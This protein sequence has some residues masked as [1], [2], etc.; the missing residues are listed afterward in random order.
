MGFFGSHDLG[1]L[2]FSIHSY[3]LNACLAVGTKHEREYLRYN[4]IKLFTIIYIPEIFA[5][6]AC[7][8]FVFNAANADLAPRSLCIFLATGASAAQICPAPAAI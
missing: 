7:L 1:M 2:V 4:I 5:V 8:I 3:L 6:R